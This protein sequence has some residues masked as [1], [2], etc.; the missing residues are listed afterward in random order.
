[1]KNTML[2]SLNP[3]ATHSPKWGTELG[4]VPENTNSNAA[5]SAPPSRKLT[6]QGPAKAAVLTMAAMAFGALLSAAPS[7]AEAATPNYRPSAIRELDLG[8]PLVGFDD[9][10]VD[11]AEKLTLPGLAYLVYDPI[12]RSEMYCLTGP[13]QAL[14]AQ[15]RQAI[16]Q[17]TLSQARIACIQAYGAEKDCDVITNSMQITKQGQESF[18]F[19]Q[20]C[21]SS[22]VFS[23]VI[24]KHSSLEKCTK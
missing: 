21:W 19:A 7:P 23:R 11:Y 14:T 20:N 6:Q 15:S 12:A 17:T 10:M 13:K 4:F 9:P 8:A 3:V 2:F 5:K 22:R 18:D 24:I 16:Q 1:M